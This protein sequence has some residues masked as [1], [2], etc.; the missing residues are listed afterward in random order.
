MPT[1]DIKQNAWQVGALLVTGVGIGGLVGLSASPVVSI[2]IT[3]VTGSAAAVVA[4]LSGMK[5]DTADKPSPWN[6]DPMPLGLLVLGLIVGSLVGLYMRTHNALSP[7]TLTLT[8]E[9]TKWTIAGLD[10]SVVVERLFEQEY[11]PSDGGGTGSTSPATVLDT[12]LFS[13]K[14]PEECK[15]LIGLAA[16][17]KYDDVRT[18]LLSSPVPPFRELP[19]IVT[20]TV[21]LAQIVDKVL[22]ADTVP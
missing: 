11:P 10:K 3:S 18:E 15:T 20:D 6:I 19:T 17:E 5:S 22:C 16:K 14:A 1:K 7:N 8:E 21:K 9:I 12:V 4:A 2:V 13:N